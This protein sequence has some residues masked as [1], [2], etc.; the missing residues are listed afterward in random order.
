MP[1]YEYECDSCLN[2]F[3]LQQSMKDEPLQTC[4]NCGARVRRIFG[5][6]SVIFKGTGFYCADTK[7]KTEPSCPN[8]ESC[9]AC[10]P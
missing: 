8:K 2:H 7:T 3:E 6:N 10:N 5:L 4:P 1:I 9:S